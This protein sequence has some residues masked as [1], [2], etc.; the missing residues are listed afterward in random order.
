MSIFDHIFKGK[1]ENFHKAKD[2]LRNAKKKFDGFVIS[3]PDV[4]PDEIMF[5]KDQ[6]ETLPRSLG[7]GIKIMALNFNSEVKLLLTSYQPNSFIT[8][9]KHYVEFEMGQILKGS[10][11][12]KL[13]GEVYNVGDS[14]KFQPNEIHFLQSAKDGCLVYSALTVNEDY[15]YANLSKERLNTL[16]SA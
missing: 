12:N 10:L 15:T 1:N 6:W 9:H 8:P 2:G 7:N 4:T 14:Y 11:T 16:K 3:F 13:T 5:I